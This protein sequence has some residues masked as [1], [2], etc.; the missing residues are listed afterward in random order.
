VDSA[1]ANSGAASG[2][3]RASECAADLG[4][5]VVVINARE[6]KVTGRKADQKLYRHHTG[7]PG[8]LKEIPFKQMMEK[9]P[10]RVRRRLESPGRGAPT[11]GGR[12]LTTCCCLVRPRSG[13][14]Y[15]RRC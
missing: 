4:D 3:P 7:F 11:A 8:G 15:A 14:L 5:Y 12:G 6:I 10:E 13:Y 2:S 1:G 9:H